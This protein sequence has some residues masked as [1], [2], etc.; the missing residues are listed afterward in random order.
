M[1]ISQTPLRVSF[2]GGGTDFARYYREHEGA[3]VSSAIDKYVFVVVVPRFDELIIVNYSKK[4]TVENVRDLQH[5]LVREDVYKR[6]T[7]ASSY[8]EGEVHFT[9]EQ[10]RN[11]RVLPATMAPTWSGEAVSYTHL[12]GSSRRQHLL[13][14][15]SAL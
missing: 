15:S 1:I 13:K 14:A 8:P 12:R 3:V 10:K 5:E 2:A 4:E 9:P 6:Q 11:F 7:L